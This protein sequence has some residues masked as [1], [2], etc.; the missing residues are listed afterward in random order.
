MVYGVYLLWGRQTGHHGPGHAGLSLDGRQVGGAGLDHLLQPVDPVHLGAEVLA[1]E[2]DRLLK[3]AHRVN[4][5][6]EGVRPGESK[7]I[8]RMRSWSQECKLNVN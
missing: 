3:L 1:H 2:V 4:S 6:F 8:K 5:Q 7:A